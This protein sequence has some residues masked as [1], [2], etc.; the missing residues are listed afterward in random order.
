MDQQRWAKIQNIFLEASVLAPNLQASYVRQHTLG[1]ADIEVEITRLLRGHNQNSVLD[2]DLKVIAAG[3]FEQPE[4][5]QLQSIGPYQLQEKLGAGGMGTV[6]LATRDDWQ[7]KV[8]LKM[9]RD[10]WIS[11][12]RLQRFAYEQLLLAR[13]VHPSI[14][15]IYESGALPNGTPWF[16]ME[17]VNGRPINTYCRDQLLPLRQRLKLFVAVCDAVAYAHSQAIIHRDLKPSNILVTESGAVKLLDF[18]IAKQL[19]EYGEKAA[20][21]I[22]DRH[23]V[24]LAYAAPE[25][26]V[27]NN[28][29]T[30][31]DVYSL[32][33]ILYEL[34]TGKLPFDLTDLSPFD[35]EKF[36]STHAPEQASAAARAILPG[37]VSEAEP[38]LS[39]TAWSD[40]DALCLKAMNIA[41]DRRYLSVEALRND[42]E[43][44]LTDQPLEAQ[45]DHWLYK[46]G[47]YARRNRKALSIATAAFIS[48]AGLV[49]YSTIRIARARDAAV[50]EANRSQ[51]L[52]N[53]LLSL[54]NGNDDQAGPSQDLKVT[55]V[56]RSGELQAAALN[57]DPRVQADLYEVLGSSYRRLGKMQ[58]A[59]SLLQ[60]ALLLRE[61]LLGSESPEVA[62][63]LIEQALS[64]GDQSHFDAAER[65]AR[66]GLD[67]TEKQKP[68]NHTQIAKALTAL[69]QVLAERGKNQEAISVLN[70]AADMEEKSMA[71]LPDRSNTLNI[72]VVA[73]ENAGDFPLAET[74]DRRLIVLDRQL[75][76]ESHPKYA[77]DLSNL[78]TSFN[79]RGNYLEAEKHYRSALASFEKWYGPD[80]PQ[81]AFSLMVLGS[82][83]TREGKLSEASLTLKRALQLET[84]LST[85]PSPQLEFVL[86]SLGGVALK[87]GEL[88]QAKQ[89]YE[90][91][92]A[93]SR[94]SGEASQRSG[95]ET[96][97]LGD[98]YSAEKNYP[99]AEQ[100]YR[101]AFQLLS[102]N[103]PPGN[104]NVGA[105]QL[106]IGHTLVLE[107]RFRD[108]EPFLLRGYEVVSRQVSPTLSWSVNGRK[109]LATVY[110][111]LN[112][113]LKAAQFR[114]APDIK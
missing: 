44:F 23:P 96:S 31:S 35:A 62:E 107:R 7:T 15:R 19:G 12:D 41:Q 56:L 64:Q 18:G 2:Q 24:T 73:H 69:G 81:T 99:R 16:A 32:G 30:R 38:T 26:M 8:A 94:I 9:P 21:T 109:D 60:K 54:F 72:L 6:Y 36:V 88:N 113:P 39:K 13:M 55:T 58:E 108:A 51:L 75:Y 98:V 5:R 83:L 93:L 97:N 50:L 101:Q 78:A 82:V 25:Q 46:T 95:L 53:F 92:L 79:A 3:V 74:L 37:S 43:R 66:H 102:T 61:H 27:K 45:P 86:D 110:D 90:K 52:E 67:L 57:S 49:T 33:V 65:L 76:G 17:Y 70:R 106:K 68:Q 63:T 91:A 48:I 114:A 112:Q 59:D 10:I 11:S 103:F 80:S 28:V 84:H 77:T 71:P 105:A 1:E 100:L 34:L 89:Y 29:S 85:T 47:K 104:I 111:H 14:A 42:I 87:S 4:V 22:G 40:L 20:I